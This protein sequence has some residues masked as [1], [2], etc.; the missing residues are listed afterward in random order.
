[1]V[2][3]YKPDEVTYDRKFSRVTSEGESCTMFDTN[4]VTNVRMLHR[5]ASDGEGGNQLWRAQL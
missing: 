5:V 3:G 2:A 4:E 1:M